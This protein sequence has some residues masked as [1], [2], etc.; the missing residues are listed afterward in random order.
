MYSNTYFELPLATF[1]PSWGK[2]VSNSVAT[3]VL[4]DVCSRKNA[5]FIK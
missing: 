1:E 4:F 2:N 3:A 5:N